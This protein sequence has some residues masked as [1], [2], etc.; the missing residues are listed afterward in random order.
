MV[1]F[2]GLVGG[3]GGGDGDGNGLHSLLQ[4]AKQRQLYFNDADVKEFG[5]KNCSPFRTIMDRQTTNCQRHTLLA[6]EMVENGGGSGKFMSISS[7][8][9][10]WKMLLLSLFLL[11]FYLNFVV[12][13]KSIYL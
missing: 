1:D 8:R 12:F 6:M 9:Q 10:R 5:Q 11:F 7:D 13:G 2:S 4:G 3:G